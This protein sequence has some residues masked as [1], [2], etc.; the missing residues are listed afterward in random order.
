MTFTEAKKI[1]VETTN[2]EM[3]DMPLDRDIYVFSLGFLVRAMMNI[4]KNN[5]AFP[6]GAHS[7]LNGLPKVSRYTRYVFDK[8]KRVN[9]HIDAVNPSPAGKLVNKLLSYVLYYRD[10]FISE[11]GD[12]LTKEDLVNISAALTTKL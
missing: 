6:N 5:A 9:M 7:L 1:I 12:K 3:A 11:Y 10:N 2:E 8:Y 4:D